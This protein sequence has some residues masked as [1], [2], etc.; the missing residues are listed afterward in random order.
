M[1][2]NTETLELVIH[3]L[4]YSNQIKNINMD[5]E[6]EAIRFDWRGNR[7]RVSTTSFNVEEVGDG[8]LSSTSAAILMQKLLKE[9]AWH[10]I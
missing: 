2:K 9:R 8:V 6:E 7:Y 10:E 4:P 1:T 5:G 3:A